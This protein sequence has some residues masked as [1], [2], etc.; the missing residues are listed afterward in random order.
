MT[1]DD[2]IKRGPADADALGTNRIRAALYN[3][4]HQS[5]VDPKDHPQHMA[6]YQP[7]EMFTRAL[8][9]ADLWR[10]HIRHTFGDIAEF[11]VRYG[12]D[13]VRLQH[14]RALWEPQTETRHIWGFDTFTGHVGSTDA[15]GD[16]EYAQDGA[17]AV[18]EGHAS[19]LA[20]LLEVHG[21]W[22]TL[23]CGDVR[24]TLPE[25]L[26]DQPQ[27]IFG[28]V[29]LDLDLYEPTRAVL[30]AIRPRLHPGS[31]VLFDELGSASYP[32][33]TRALAETWGLGELR[34]TRWMTSQAYTVL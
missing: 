23:V 19:H 21:G 7:R 10:R 32:G 20:D 12:L 3:L 11:G 13:L 17:F 26:E 22:A 31:V 4:A 24:E 15:D 33:E 28:F 14:L 6:L 8:M 34:R 9:F 2:I 18:P 5:T 16:S 29:I 30:E 1:V 27:L 25:V